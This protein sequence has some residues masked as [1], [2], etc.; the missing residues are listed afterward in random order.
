MA[1]FEKSGPKR[2]KPH[3]A[4]AAQRGRRAPTPPSI[5][6]TMFFPRLRRHAKWM[7]VFL[8]LVFGL[9][10]V[11]FG[12]GAGGVGFGDVLRGIGSGGGPSVEAAREKTEERPKDAAAWEELS[13]ALQ[14]EGDTAGAIEAQR[15]LATLKPKDPDVLRTLAALQIA[16]VGEKQT[17]AQIIQ[18]NAAINAASQN[19]PSLTLGGQSVLDDPIGQAINAEANAQVQAIFLEAQAA[20]TGA[21]DAYKKLVA[22]QPKDPGVQLELAQAAQQTGD[23]ATAIAAYERFLVLSPDDPN[24][25]AVKQQLKQL[26]AS[27]VA[28]SG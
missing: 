11:A 6:D 13:T 14:A 18:G 15:Q 26:R 1:R 7:F 3:A 8:A 27:Q 25:A 22:L 23:I 19:F 9:G 2:A 5:E 16:L 24:A 20:A 10:F 21:V 4:V 28:A 12:V 17:E